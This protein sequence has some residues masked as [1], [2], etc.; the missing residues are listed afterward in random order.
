ME[1]HTEL[2]EGEACYYKDTDEG[3]VDLDSLSYIDEKIQHAL[4]HFQKDFE[5]GVS[6]ENLGAKF[7]CYG[8]FLPTYERSPC[9]RSHSKIP[10]RNHSSPKSPINVHIEAVSHNTEAPSNVPPSARLGNASYSPH[11]FHD[12]RAPSVD[13]SVLKGRR[14][15]SGDAAERCTL[16]D[17]TTKKTGNSTDQR[18]LKFR[19][20]MKSHIL[21]QK[22]AAIY[23]GLGLDS[24]PSSSMGNSPVESE[25]M[26]PVSQENTEDYVTA[27]IQDM[28]SFSIPGGVLISP[29]HESFLSLIKEEKV[30]QDNRYMSPL[31]GHQEPFPMSTDESDSFAEDGHLKKTKVRQN[32]KQLQL[33]NMNGTISEEDMTLHTKKMFGNRTPDRKDFLSN[34]LKRTPL[35]SSICDAGETAEVTAKASEVS[36][37]VN[38]NGLQGRMVFV[39]ALKEESLESISGQDFKKIEK[40]NAGNGFMKNVL[41]HKLE[42][43]RKDN[44]TDRKN[45]DKCNA[46]MISKMV[47][48]DAV[49][50]KVDQVP[51]KYETHQK[52]TAVNEGKNKSKGVQIPGKA[53]AVARRDSFGGSNDAMI[54]DKGSAG[55]GI[56][57]RSKMNKSKSL[58]DKKVKHSNEDSLKEKKSEW[59]VDVP[60]GN[61]AM[62]DANI[63]NFKKQSVF[64]AKVKERP[65]GN[66]VVNQ[67]LDGPCIKDASGSFPIAENGPAPEMIAS[68]VAAPQL[69]AEDWVCCDSCEQ[70]RLLPTGIKPDQLPKKWL[71]SMLN[72]LPG[73]NSCDFSEDDTTKALYASYQVPISVS[74]NK[75]QSHANGSAIGVSSADALQFGPSLKKSGSDVKFDRGKKKHVIK[76][77]TMAGIKNDMLQFSNSGKLNAPESG[78]NRSLIDMNQHPAGSDPM[79]KLN[80]KYFSGLNNLIDEKDMPKEKEKHINGGDRKHIKSKRKM[81]ADQYRSGTP[82]KSKTDVCYA[83]KQLNPGMGLEKVALNSGNGL[84]TKA[85]GRDRRKSDEYCLSEDVQDKLLVPV[86]KEGD[87]AQVSSGG[88]PLGVKNSSKSDGSMKKRKLKGW[89]D[90]EKH[91]NTYSLYGD[92]QCGEEDNSNKFRKEKKSRIFNED[93]KSVT[94]GDDKSSKGG[95]SQVSLTGS[96]DQM[97]LGTEVRF[98]DKAH[99]PRKHR[100]NIASRQSVDDTNPLGKQLGS[101]QLS[102]AATSSSSKVSGSYKAKTNFE[103]VRGLPVK[104]V[105]S[106]HLRNSNFDKRVLAV[107]DVSGKDDSTKG[108]LSST[109]SRRCEDNREGKQSVKLKGNRISYNL[110]PASDKLSSI[111]YRVEDAKDK[112]RVLAKTSSGVK[113]NHLIESGILVEQHGNCA[114]AMHHV[115][116]VNKDNQESELSWQKSGKVTSLHSKEKDRRSGSQVGTD[117]MK[118]SASENDYSK[119]GRSYDSAVDPS[120][121]AYGPETTNST[122]H[123]SPKFKCEI[124]SISE[125]SALKHGSSD[126]GKQTKLKQKDFENSV[127]KMDAQ[128]STDRKTISQQNLTRDFEEENKANH[129]CTELRDGKSKILS[130]AVGEVKRETLYVGSRTVPRYQK[131]DMSSEHPVHVRGNGNGAKLMRNSA[132]VSSNNGINHSSGNFSPDQQL[133]LLS[134]VRTNSSHTAINTL[135]EA[136]K[137]KDRADHYKEC[138]FDFESNE[139]Y[140]QAGLKF[141][142][143][144][145]L[146]ENC[147]GESSKHGERSQMQIYATTAELF[148]SCAYEYES[149]QEMAAAALAYKCMEV[150]Y[151]RV[152]YCKQSSTIRDRHELQST[153]Q[154]VSQ[155]ES[156]SSSA[157]DVDNLNNQAAMD[158]A[159]LPK[160]T[161]GSQVAGNQAISAQTRSTLVRLL[162]F[163]PDVNFA[164]EACR[165]CQSA[166]TAAKLITEEA[167]NTN[168]ITSIRRV[169]DFSFQDLDELV[170]LVWIATIAISGAGLGGARD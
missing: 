37:E 1:A 100:K 12:L 103:D 140:F 80:S 129:V 51:Q 131:G 136:T 166:F 148:K 116:K 75:M 135:E 48:H 112:T 115:K 44:S 167:R 34:D 73:M 117:N 7:G 11:S 97:V 86:K 10:Q 57:H 67:L 78:K 120:Y 114:N 13:N 132:D 69:I 29:L 46:N 151:T 123:S 42:S 68:A 162:D 14:I 87:Q 95:M 137:L 77:K 22:N 147:H 71:C 82:K 59:K 45:N 108:G 92:K 55:F 40:T 119:N 150:A 74:Q 125:K 138:G 156:P 155:G 64:G 43:F 142:H 63:N 98:A 17:D 154:M 36:K 121:H 90:N 126:S 163:T 161:T 83:D 4:G 127:L 124:D 122:K 56:T 141:L 145:S 26:P 106:S 32:E 65:S 79:K 2:E 102:L 118:V 157:S 81:D 39:E 105:T 160:G 60:P 91:N 158:K 20:K 35:S 168:C 76:E 15:S 84:P 146:L 72:W 8:S 18:P 139:T 128:C 113:N 41:E 33:K 6:A 62:K 101:G 89:L 23:S 134:S 58:K 50:C 25:G 96:R 5:G 27:I 94:E 149:R 38:E 21:A 85:R 143:G 88:E 16:K 133:A 47:E 53:E 165:K 19:I 170:R 3:N 61:S 104:S 66:K 109:G 107:K 111:E 93:A 9:F 24:S 28:T 130:S 169:I 110:H 153:L 164:M 49:K 31:N 99:Q 144:A 54:T 152:V 159:T 70:W 52:V 30:I